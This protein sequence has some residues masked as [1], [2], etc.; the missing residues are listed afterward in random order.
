MII[1][2]GCN[3]GSNLTG[4]KTP[5]EIDSLIY[6][7][8]SISNFTFANGI[9]TVYTDTNIRKLKFEYDLTTNDSQPDSLVS[10]GFFVNGYP[11]YAYQTFGKF[12]IGHVNYTW[13]AD[14][15]VTYLHIGFGIGYK[16]QSNLYIKMYNITIHRIYN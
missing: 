5:T 15:G 4:S 6:E 2:F 7:Y 9:D 11:S 10:S 1:F 13:I 12:N 16:L 8:D 14:S 3:K